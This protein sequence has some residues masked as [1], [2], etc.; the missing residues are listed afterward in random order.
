M[1]SCLPVVRRASDEP[2]PIAARQGGRPFA[3]LE[4]KP[5]GR[6]RPRSARMEPTRTPESA[7]E[8][9][10]SQLVWADDFLSPK[11]KWTARRI[12]RAVKARPRVPRIVLAVGA[13]C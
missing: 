8:W 12:A 1:G 11:R 2:A 5:P 7:S 4:E 3:G 10:R 6:P 13:E 9:L